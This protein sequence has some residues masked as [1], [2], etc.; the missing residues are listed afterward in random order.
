MRRPQLLAKRVCRARR[1][2]KKFSEQSEAK[3]A[4]VKNSESELIRSRSPGNLF[5]G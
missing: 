3:S 1:K 4:K 2:A 5:A